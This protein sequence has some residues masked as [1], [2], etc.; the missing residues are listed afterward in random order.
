[1]PLEAV[2]FDMDGVV[3]DTARAHAAAWKRLFDA[4]IET[5]TA[6]AGEDLRP[7]DPRA[8]YLAYVDGR[9]RLGGIRCFLKSRGIELPE[10]APGEAAGLATIHALGQLKNQYFRIWLD[11]HRVQA[12]PGTLA[13]L[14]ELRRRSIRTGLF[15]SSRNANPVLESAGVVQLF[16]VM[17]DGTVSAEQH[18]PGKPDPAILLHTADRLGVP[19]DAAAVIE[20]ATA[21]VAAGRHGGFALV[22]GVD[23]GGNRQALVEHGADLVV[24]DLANLILDQENVLTVKRLDELPLV[25]DD[26]PGLQRRL[27]RHRL[28]VFLDYDGTLAPIVDDPENALIGDQMRDAVRR[29]A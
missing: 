2:L 19:P 3:T 7:F 12:F 1:M 26:E 29:L 4:L 13:L 11:Q 24:D 6:R 14:H 10:G 22:I 17:V 20:D 5:R 27:D 8:D 21:G 23:R 9:P 28:A 16:D 15:T 18:L 25:L